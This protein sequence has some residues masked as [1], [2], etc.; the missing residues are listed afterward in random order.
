MDTIT[1]LTGITS[2]QIKNIML[3]SFVGCIM[4][5]V[6]EEF[7]TI[8][9][10]IAYPAFMSF[11][12][13][14]TKQTDDDKQW[15]TYWIVFGAFNIIDHFADVITNFIPFYLALKVLFL[16]YL[17]HPYTQGALMIYNGLILPNV[18]KYQAQLDA[19]DEKLE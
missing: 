16:I 12:A 9:V 7:V 15:L 10:G 13:L 3:L 4:L 1:E 14:E 18:E 8:A 5:G 6:G 2:L 19:I 17:M 11:L